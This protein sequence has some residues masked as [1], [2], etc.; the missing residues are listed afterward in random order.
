[1][2]RFTLPSISD[3]VWGLLVVTV[4]LAHYFAGELSW[5]DID[6]LAV[7]VYGALTPLAL[8]FFRRR[9]HRPTTS[10]KIAASV[11]AFLFSQFVT[12]GKSYF[13]RHDWSLCFGSE[14]SVLIWALQ[15]LCYCYVFYTIVLGLFGLLQQSDSGVEHYKLNAL[16]WFGALF[17]VRIIYLFLLFPCTFDIDAAIGLS[18]FLDPDSAICNHHPILVQSLHALFFSIGKIIGYRSVGIAMLTVLQ[19]CVSCGILTYGLSLA[20]QSGIGKRRTVI[21][22]LI[23]LLFP[24]FSFLS[25]FITKDGMFAYA[26]LFY[27]F[28]LYELFLSKGES[29]HNKRFLIFHALSILYLCLTRHQGVFFVLGEF[30]LLIFCYRQYWRQLLY[31]N[32]LPLAAFFCF[33]NLLLPRLDVEPPGKQEVYGTLFHQT[34]S[35]IHQYPDELSDS[36]RKAIGNILDYDMLSKRYVYDLTDYS[37]DDYKYNP[38]YSSPDTLVAFHHVDR[39]SEKADIKNYRKAWFSMFL[40]HPFCYLQATLGVCI[41]FFYNNCNLLVKNESYWNNMPFSQDYI[42][43]YY[44]KFEWIYYHQAKNLVKIPIVNWLFAIPYYIWL[45][46]VALGLLFCRK[47]WKSLS[48]FLPMVLSVL[49]LIICPYASGRYAFPIVAALPLLIIHVMTS[50]SSQRCQK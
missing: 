1:M 33:S 18:T 36:E 28:T 11:L 4:A 6:P 3:C 31:V 40:R 50:N 45:T 20:A 8:S 30:P 25:V 10:Q 27:L 21:L 43:G 17:F 2:T 39:T 42:F 41:G 47:D 7:F 38:M 49:F 37:K 13:T 34:A 14:L 48:I 35:Y 23:Y 5:I 12:I 44:E 32:L 26:F 9:F 24:F 16:H 19:I 46:L 22:A 15:T 29:L